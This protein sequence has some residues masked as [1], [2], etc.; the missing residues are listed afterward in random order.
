MRAVKHI[1]KKPFGNI[2]L[3]QFQP[4]MF[5]ANQRFNPIFKLP[6]RELHAR[7]PCFAPSMAR[8]IGMAR[9]NVNR[10]KFQTVTLPTSGWAQRE[11]L[12]FRFACH[13]LH[14]VSF[15]PH[16]Q[17]SDEM[18]VEEPVQGPSHSGGVRALVSMELSASNERLDFTFP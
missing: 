8:E 3:G 2:F 7:S 13:A 10:F 18:Q 15:R 17:D 16:S 4:G 5:A 6:V 14:G 9:T 1:P 12:G 11:P